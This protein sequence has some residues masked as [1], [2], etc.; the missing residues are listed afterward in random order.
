M[1]FWFKML[2]YSKFPLYRMRCTEFVYERHLPW[3]LRPLKVLYHFIPGHFI[4][5]Q[6]CPPRTLYPRS[7]YPYTIISPYEYPRDNISPFWISLR[8]Y[9]PKLNIPVTVYPHCTV[10][11]NCNGLTVRTYSDNICNRKCRLIVCMD[12]S[13]VVGMP[14]PPLL[15]MESQIA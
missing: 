6:L 8:H 12:V 11:C 3:P 9:I 14:T 7:F 4:S 15:C 13:T 1:K 5:L 2:Q 10:C